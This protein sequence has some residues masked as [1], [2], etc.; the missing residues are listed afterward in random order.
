MCEKS[1]GEEA[2]EDALVEE[3]GL[4]EDSWTTRDGVTMLIRDMTDE[5]LS[6]AINLLERQYQEA[7]SSGWEIA[8]SGMCRLI[9]LEIARMEQRI[10]RLR[11][12]QSS[13]VGE[14]DYIVGMYLHG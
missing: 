13:R 5:H 6:N 10:S 11:Y 3:A 1:M 9:G 8:P 4:N 2:M 7:S 12:E 14:T